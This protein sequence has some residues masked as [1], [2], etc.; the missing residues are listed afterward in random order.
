ML[1]IGTSHSNRPFCRRW[2]A[3]VYRQDKVERRLEVRFVQGQWR[4][5]PH[6]CKELKTQNG[7]KGPRSRRKELRRAH[8]AACEH[9]TH[10]I[11][12]ARPGSWA[13]SATVE[14]VD[15]VV[16]CLAGLTMHNDP[17]LAQD[18]LVPTP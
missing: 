7:P 10:K 1:A 13:E 18:S 14:C 16:A 3:I 4:K 11:S 9:F 15:R 12:P 8:R 6:L 2:T 5:E 17:L